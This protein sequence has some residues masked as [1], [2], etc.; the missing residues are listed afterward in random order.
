MSEVKQTKK[1]RPKVIFWQLVVY[2]GNYNVIHERHDFVSQKQAK[3]YFYNSDKITHYFKWVVRR[4]VKKA[5][6]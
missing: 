1:G 2:D 6:M 5:C 4:F 3:H